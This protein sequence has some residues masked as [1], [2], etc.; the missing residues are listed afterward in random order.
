MGSGEID[1]GQYDEVAERELTDDVFLLVRRTVFDR[2]GGYD[3][4]FAYYGHENVDWCLRMRQAG[5]RIMY[6]PAAKLWH[7]GRTGGA[8]TAFYLYHQTR[9]DYVLV[10]NT[11]AGRRPSY[12]P[13]C[14]RYGTSRNRLWSACGRRNSRR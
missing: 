2:P 9:N 3:E 10:A 8:W 12:R 14:S 6:A 11:S 4:D 7:K 5:F 13:R 1:H